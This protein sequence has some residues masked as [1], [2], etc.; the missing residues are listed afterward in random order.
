[1][2]IGREA[3]FAQKHLLHGSTV[4][5]AELALP[6]SL[7]RPKSRLW[8][9]VRSVGRVSSAWSLSRPFTVAWPERNQALKK[10]RDE[11]AKKNAEARAKLNALYAEEQ[12]LGLRNTNNAVA[13]ATRASSSAKRT[14]S[15]AALDFDY[16]TY[17]RLTAPA[18]FTIDWPNE[19]TIRG[20]RIY[21]LESEHK[22]GRQNLRHGKDFRFL[23]WEG[24]SWK[25]VLKVSGN[26]S[27]H[28]VHRFP[29]PAKT[30]RLLIEI[31]SGHSDTVG[32]RE[33][34]VD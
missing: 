22:K 31:E 14:P 13:R 3:L 19:L 7:L 6:R 1:V 11:V 4:E 21:W 16:R 20:V 25:E 34:R 9:R 5:A 32:I 24:D 2:Q 17:V 33:L 27:R 18:S 30:S 29:E 23:R 12:R 10:R 15:G 8:W 28:S 26:G